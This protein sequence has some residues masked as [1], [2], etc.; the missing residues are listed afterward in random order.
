MPRKVSISDA[1]DLS[2]SPEGSFE[3]SEYSF[4]GDFKLKKQNMVSHCIA[5]VE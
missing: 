5:C 4:H 2:V 1:V 3:L